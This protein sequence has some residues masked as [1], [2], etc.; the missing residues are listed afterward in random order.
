M[1]AVC[2]AR[3]PETTAD[4]VAGTP[5]WVWGLTALHVLLGAVTVGLLRLLKRGR[6]PPLVAVCR[7]CTDDIIARKH[8]PRWF[9]LALVCCSFITALVSAA[10]ELLKQVSAQWPTPAL[11]PLPPAAVLIAASVVVLL[12]ALRF[13]K[14]MRPFW[15]ARVVAAPGPL[16]IGCAWTLSAVPLFFLCEAGLNSPGSLPMIPAR[17]TILSWTSTAPADGHRIEEDAIV[18]RWLGG[19][20]LGPHTVVKGR[21]AWDYSL[22]VDYEVDGVSRQLSVNGFDGPSTGSVCWDAM[23]FDNAKDA[24]RPALATRRECD[25]ID[26]WFKSLAMSVLVA[27]SPAAF[28]WWFLRW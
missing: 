13:A 10:A 11:I 4:K 15:R 2:R 23:T 8:R 6:P 25:D 21:H 24:P 22:L 20:L 7:A 12:L 16:T 26:D 3:A 1:C 17:A 28:A 18:Q 5:V 19:V 9:A 14:R 27:P